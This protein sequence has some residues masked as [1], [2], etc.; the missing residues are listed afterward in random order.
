MQG[1]RQLNAEIR[2]GSKGY[3]MKDG[4]SK[5]RESLY[6]IQVEGKLHEQWSDWFN[7]M[8][9]DVESFRDNYPVTHLCGLVRDQA[10]LLGILTRICDLNLTLISVQRV[11]SDRHPSL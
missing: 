8:T 5:D 3:E 6:E 1:L 9:I 11:E 10:A 2:T 4:V 7:G